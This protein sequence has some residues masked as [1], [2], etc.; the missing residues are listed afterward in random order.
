MPQV[1]EII[2]CVDFPIF[3]HIKIP[4]KGIITTQPIQNQDL[5][6][7]LTYALLLNIDILLIFQSLNMGA[8][9]SRN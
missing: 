1:P 4:A 9:G 8:P 5:L 2:F 7:Q 6:L 3:S